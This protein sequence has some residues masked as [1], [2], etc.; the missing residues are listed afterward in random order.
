MGPGRGPPMMGGPGMRAPPPPQRGI[1]SNQWQRKEPLPA[2]APGA[3]GRA[4]LPIH[5]AQS[6]WH[7]SPLECEPSNLVFL[8]FGCF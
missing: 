1:E 3:G 4:G 6:R 7:V 2:G 8:E 5:K